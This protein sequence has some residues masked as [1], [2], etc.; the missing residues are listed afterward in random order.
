MKISIIGTG[1]VGLVQG[2][3]FADSGN[4]VICMD[5]DEK[6]I[7][8][9]KRGSIPIY[10]PGLEEMVR[11]NV[12]DGRLEF[13]TSL[14]SAVEKSD[15]IFL[16]LPTPQS[17]DG[18]AD[19]SHVLNVAESIADHLNGEK[20]V[21][22]KSTVPVGT[23]DKIKQIIR[24]KTKHDVEVV[25][26]PEFLKEGAALQDSLKP[27]R[28]ILGTKSKKA[29]SIL[30]ELYE[31]FIRTG[32]PII[33][34]DERSA[35]MTKYAANAFLATKISFM[36]EL[37][38]ICERV[39]ADIDL[40]RKGIG[41]DPRI[42]SQFLFAGVGYGGSCFPKDVKALVKT[43]QQHEYD[44]KILKA[45]DE[46]NEKQKRLLIKKLNRY[47]NNQVAGKTIAVWGLSFKPQTDDLREAPSLVIIN[48]L[49]QSGAKVKAH[50]PVAIPKAK[51]MLDGKL[52]L[53]DNNYDALKGAD[54]LL[55]V[56]EWNEFRRPDF[57]KMKSLMK[58]PVIFDGRNIYDPK[59][60]KE[61]GFVYFGVGR[62]GSG[63]EGKL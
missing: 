51:A 34:M 9:L 58:K 47:F 56:T 7:N 26:N 30:S 62:G 46:I 16:C 54:A 5:I 28:I 20:V 50:D 15:I 24:R 39:G 10:E 36:N 35:E 18:S 3:C 63:G 37:A 1:Y 27:D 40:V 11:K 52:D 43:A 59:E 14:K 21:V 25:S 42:G 57:E 60:M 23:V 17:D 8:A 61:R 55:I 2:A 4:N 22:S 13:T 29:I 41:T 53:V 32:N 45:V 6:K 48:S 33:V 19:L 12:Q 31:P 38:N 44:F 49:L